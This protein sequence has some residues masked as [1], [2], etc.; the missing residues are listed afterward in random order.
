[1]PLHHLPINSGGPESNTAAR[2]PD[3][4]VTDFLHCRCHKW[5][6]GERRVT[7]VVSYASITPYPPEGAAGFEPTPFDYNQIEV[8]V[9]LHYPETR[10]GG[11]APPTLGAAFSVPRSH[12]G[13]SILL[14]RNRK[15]YACAS[16]RRVRPGV[17]QNNQNLVV[18]QASYH[19]TSNAIVGAYDGI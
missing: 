12:Q 15:P 6:R 13:R 3:D 7:G 19:W 11:L 2:S 10:Q 4:E 16:S 9:S 14:C 1:M 17:T 5:Y 8:P 18:S